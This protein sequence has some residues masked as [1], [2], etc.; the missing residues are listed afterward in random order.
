[1]GVWVG[2]EGSDVGA[3]MEITSH[4][5]SYRTEISRRS[6]IFIEHNTSPTKDN[7]DWSGKSKSQS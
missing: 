3:G 2:S 5:S 6:L 7:A 4:N 1:M